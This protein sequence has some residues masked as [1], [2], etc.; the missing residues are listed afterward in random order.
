MSLFSES[1]WIKVLSK[2]YN[3]KIIGFAL[4][5]KTNEIILM[6]PDTELEN[7]NGSSSFGDKSII[8]FNVKRRNQS[9]QLSSLPFSDYSG[10]TGLDF[11]DDLVKMLE[12]QY[13]GTIKIEIR[14]KVTSERFQSKLIGYRHALDLNRTK[15]DIFRGF[16]KTQ[17]QQPILKSLREGLQYSINTDYGSIEKFYYLHLL[18]RKKLGLPIQPKKFFI[19]FW[20]EII[21][22][23]YGYIVLVSSKGKDISAG[24]YA[25]VR[26][27]ISYKFSASH[28]EY[29]KLRPNNLM[30]W[31]GIVEAQNR[32]YQI[33][34]FGRTDLE[35][36]GLRKFKLG[37]G[38]VEEP[39]YYSYY[40][41]VPDGSS[42]NYIKDKVVGPI[43]KHS[44]NFI[45]RWSGEL[46]YKYFG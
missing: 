42:F 32:G 36:E 11:S 22:K 37:W 6:T 38:A 1:L 21:S 19:N 43:I 13:T 28:P 41:S 45:C 20:G 10:F 23:G 25:G 26:S 33:F 35:T 40:P 15:D 46:L 7:G 5:Y 18:T 8:L 30:L 9:L 31:S 44:P 3:F 39:L 12:K 27:E 17:V 29:L 4:D 34:D 2:T 16:K 24:I 14:N